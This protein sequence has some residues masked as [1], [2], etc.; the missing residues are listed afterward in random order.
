VTASARELFELARQE[1]R[2]GLLT[3]IDGTVSRIAPHPEMATVDPEA[4]EVLAQ[5]ATELT[6]V[7]AVSGRSA[8]DAHQM[9]GLDELVYSGNHGMEIWRNGQLEQSQLALEYA[10]RI[11]NLLESLDVTK[12]ID[13]LFVEN[14]VLTASIHYRGVSDPDTVEQELLGE[15]E[16]RASE[17][18]L[19]I[20]RGRKVIELRPP[21]ELSKGTS[22]LELI[23]EYELE[24]LIYIGDDITDVDAFKALLELRARTGGHFYAIGVASEATPEAVLNTTNAMVN[25][26]DGVVELLRGSSVKS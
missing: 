26:V 11:S 12:R 16:I 8:E 22:V 24:S 14:K 5:V 19:R 18:G 9:I 13:G 7:G 1:D 10:P 4:R 23:R 20:T 3:D 6:L 25:G 21:V 15:V 17:A 2:A